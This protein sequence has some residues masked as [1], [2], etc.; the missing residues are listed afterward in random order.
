V[1]AFYDEGDR[2]HAKD[3]EFSLVR[4]VRVKHDDEKRLQKEGAFAE[5]D[6]RMRHRMDESVVTRPLDVGEWFLEKRLVEGEAVREINK[7]LVF[8]YPGTGGAPVRRVRNSTGSLSQGRPRSPRR[9]LTFGRQANG[10]G[11]STTCS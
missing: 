6:Q 1:P 10:G 2:R 4:F 8:G 3:L 5:E 7:V 9:S 11:S